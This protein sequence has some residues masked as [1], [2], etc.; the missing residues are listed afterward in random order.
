MKIT[1]AVLADYANVS[2]DGKLNIMGIFDRVG[3]PSVPVR[4]PEMRLVLQM[5]AEPVELGREHLIEIR[6]MDQDGDDLFRIEANVTISK[7][8]KSLKSDHIL[9]IRGLEFK[10][11]G[12]HTFSV[13]INNDLKKQLGF[14]V[15]KI[16]DQQP[17]LPGT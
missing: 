2:Q 14:D 1:L 16:D 12:G 5:E 4:H 3:V 9:D 15:V 7:E 10:K 11:V 8:T 13:F 17:K 6:C